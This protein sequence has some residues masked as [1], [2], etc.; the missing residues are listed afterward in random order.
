MFKNLVRLVIGVFFAI[1]LFISF[2]PQQVYATSVSDNFN[3]ANGG[4]GSNWTTMTGTNAPQISSNLLQ[5][6]TANTVNAAFW[7]ANSFANDQYVQAKM[8]ASTG[9]TA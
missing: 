4:L 7:T 9:S 6:G 1:L 8:P 3:R 2:S 5:P